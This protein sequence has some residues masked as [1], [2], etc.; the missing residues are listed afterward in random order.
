MVFCP[1]RHGKSLLLSHLV[2][3]WYALKHPG[4]R[5]ILASYGATYAATWGLK[6]L[7]T[8][9][10][11]GPRYG[12]TVNPR[13]G[14][15]SDFLLSNGSGMLS[16]GVGGATTGRGADWLDMDDVIKNSEQALSERQRDTTWDWYRSVA[17]TRLEPGAAQV[18]TFTRWHEDD[19]AG[20]ILANDHD[21][22]WEVISL[23]ALALEDDPLGRAFGEPLWPERFCAEALGKIRKEIGEFWWSALYAQRPSPP[24]GVLF[25]RDA[26]RFYTLHGSTIVSGD[27]RLDASKGTVFATMDTAIEEGEAN[28]YTVLSLWCFV[29]EYLVLAELTRIKQDA[30]DHEE[31]VGQFLRDH[32][33]VEFIGIEDAPAEKVLIQALKR[34]GAPVRKLPTHG[35]SKRA[36]AQTAIT[37]WQNSRVLLPEHLRNSEVLEEIVSFDRAAHDDVVDT[38]SQAA[39]QARKMSGTAAGWGLVTCQSCGKATFGSQCGSCGVKITA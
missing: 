2:P 18:L 20:R 35:K 25:T 10:A 16:T 21:N 32:P 15:A 30:V 26:A 7:E 17:E 19:L 6:T 31:M 33:K 28:D 1:P 3:A 34:S 22:E 24:E 11:V 13:K 4:K 23:P 36:R 27:L 12:V 5:I 14:G 39:I 8:C 9:M 38:L 29:D 37:M